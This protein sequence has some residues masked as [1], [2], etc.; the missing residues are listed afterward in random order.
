MQYGFYFNADKC[1]SCKACVMACKDKND[2]LVGLKYRRVIDF[3]GGSWDMSGDVPVPQDVFAYSLSIACNHC[4]KPACVA[5]CPSG[6][7]IK[8]DE[9]GIV[10]VDES[11]CIGCGTCAKSCPYGAPTL[12]EDIKLSGKCNGCMDYLDEGKNPACVD[13]CLMRCLEFGDIEELRQKYGN[14]ADCKPLPDS[15]TTKPSLVLGL[16]SHCGKDGEII[17]TEEELL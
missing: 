11:V 15:S 3:G 14:V 1:G 2:T 16:S 17:S 5:N 13:A 12:R 8:R 10:Y 6:A 9:D 7:M 4:E